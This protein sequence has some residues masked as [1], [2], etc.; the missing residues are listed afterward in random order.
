M[1][2]F[3]PEYRLR[4]FHLRFAGEE[5][6]R[7]FAKRSLVQALP[8]IRAFL[9]L[10]STLYGLF[11]VLDVIS[12]P[13]GFWT[14]WLIRLGI[15]VPFLYGVCLF[16]FSPLF[17]R[18][19]Q[20]VLT[21][22][23]SVAGL[24]IIA[25]TAVAPPPVNA[26][27]YAGLIVVLIYCAS[28][29]RLHWTRAALISLF[30]VS[31]YQPVALWYNP[32]PF[33]IFLNNDFFLMI[34]VGLGIFTSYVQEFH[35]RSEFRNADMLRREKDRSIELMQ[36]AQT[37]ARAKSEFLSI[38]SHELRTP[39]NAIIGFS[40]LIRNQ[41]FGPLGAREYTEYIDDIYDSGHHLLS[42]ITDVLDLSKAEVGKLKLREEEV[43]LTELL[44]RCCR[45]LRNKAV[46]NG[47][48]LSLTAQREGPFIQGDPA[49]LKQVFLNLIGN[50]IKFTPA[51]G[52]ITVKFL[53]GADGSCGVA[54]TDTGI[55]IAEQDLERVFLPFSQVE[56]AYSRK[57]GGA[58]L[59]LALAKKIADL[60]ESALTL[61]STL[62]VGTTARLV[63]P[64]SRVIENQSN[65][66][67]DV[68]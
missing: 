15:I 31:I 18:H 62:G 67:S 5:V 2:N 29:I 49:L 24:G 21:V 46:E 1:E 7:T 65:G 50:A 38:V 44:S 36:E 54:V 11:A 55:G 28:L 57:H 12:L 20:L 10:G 61:E 52:S 48:R 63:F 27:Y 26:N 51:G 32:I 41:T 8:A 35:I 23:M 39:L 47:L 64:S 53:K 66:V 3:S 37:A 22:A 16:T 58:G 30:I 59:G 33:E 45:V 34:A 60:H 6:E 42:I 14:L 25:L 43:D 56:A 4:P 9:F 68:A 13:H 19:S 40:E 17:L